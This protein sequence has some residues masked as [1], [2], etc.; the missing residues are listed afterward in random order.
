[1]NFEFFVSLFFPR[2]CV[3]CSRTIRAGALCDACR[4]T[5]SVS[6]APLREQGD[7]RTAHFLGAAGDYENQALKALVHALKFQGVRAAAEPLGSLL[8]EYA[9]QAGIRAH[10]NRGAS[11]V[12]P[13]PL[14]KQRRR[15]RG[16]NQSELIAQ[17]F[18]EH[19]ALPLETKC[20]VR[21]KNARPQSETKHVIERKE[22]IR[23]CYAVVDPEKVSGK[24]ILLIDDVTTSGATFLEA[25]RTLRRAGIRDL[26]ALA[27]ARA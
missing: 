3:A 15:E 8:I 22:N 27:V 14:S 11:I 18:A 13:V 5:I 4:G 16:F 12:M 1:M 10:V 2:R 25:T 26:Y 17:R 23:D 9:T 6:R 7:A 24:D 20:L 21:V 19:F